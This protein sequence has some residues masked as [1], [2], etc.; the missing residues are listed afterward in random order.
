MEV[1]NSQLLNS[2]QALQELTQCKLPAVHALALRDV[3]EEVQAQ[4][5]KVQDVREDL[6]ERDADEDEINDEWRDLL[7]DE[8][9]LDAEPLPQQALEGAEVS[10]QTL[11]A[12]D[13][14]IA[15]D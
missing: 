15:R 12:L 3:V 5:E 14:M 6:M 11:L 7:A 10:T 1:T 2:Q 8:V 4:V 9:E 13:W